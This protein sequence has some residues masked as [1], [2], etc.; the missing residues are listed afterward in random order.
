[1]EQKKSPQSTRLNFANAVFGFSKKTV[2]TIAAT[3]RRL[4]Q[5]H[6]SWDARLIACVSG[7]SS[8]SAM[9]VRDLG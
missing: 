1:M 6:P 3:T 4:R 8:L 9:R 5:S 2:A 7:A